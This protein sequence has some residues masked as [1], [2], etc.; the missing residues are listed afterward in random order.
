M[1]QGATRQASPVQSTRELELAVVIVGSVIV[2]LAAARDASLATR[3][4][5]MGH[6]LVVV[7]SIL[8][9]RRLGREHTRQVVIAGCMLSYGA[10]WL[11]MNGPRTGAGAALIGGSTL[12]AL[13][14]RGRAVVGA[15]L[16]VAAIVACGGVAHASGWVSNPPPGTDLRELLPIAL[17]SVA[18]ATSVSWMAA[19]IASVIRNEYARSVES[20]R[21]AERERE[22]RVRAQRAL[23]SAIRYEAIGR[24]AGAIAHD[25]NNRLAVV[26]ANAE[27]LAEAEV[28][29]AELR[30]LLAELL[31]G[32]SRAAATTGDLLAM[33][34]AQPDSPA[35]VR[36]DVLAGRLE[37]LVRHT[38]SRTMTKSFGSEAGDAMLDSALEAQRVLSLLA[39]DAVDAARAGGS[40]QLDAAVEGDT[41]SVTLKCTLA[42]A[43]EVP[44]WDEFR[45]RPL[46]AELAGGG[47]RLE[48][49][50][51]E[52]ES[53]AE[54]VLRV[55]EPQRSLPTW[56]GTRKQE[57]RHILAVD[58]DVAV[59]KAMERILRRAGH[60]V[61]VAEGGH[62]ARKIFED[63]TTIDV[64][65]S[66]AIMPNTDTV[67][68][69]RAFRAAHPKAAVVICSGYV[70]DDMVSDLSQHSYAFVPKPFTA[71]T[72][73]DA[74]Q[75][76]LERAAAPG[77]G[78]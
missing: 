39:L 15:T 35:R 9:A 40:L 17:V 67:A 73:L 25:V 37:S 2:F 46:A 18:I 7:A 36:F 10:G 77:V 33:G 78:A 75:T 21:Q 11:F 27:L 53:R 65:V 63:G 8:A 26:I 13:Y 32:A 61:R 31:R 45:V 1:A 12:A 6:H 52:R 24:L 54:L 70:A 56:R 22:E 41:L 62:D 49:L 16:F 57:P 60:V 44:V 72:L 20:L 43:S 55:A 47:G 30:P 48:L 14:F 58:D 59:R 29:G 5:R 3:L 66:D 64:L 68:M 50:H 51:G 28:E 42:A 23:D 71:N 38:T 34:R 19:R 69:I 76:A 4:V 74:L